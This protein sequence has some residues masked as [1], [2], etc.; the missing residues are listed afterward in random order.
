MNSP[1]VQMGDIQHP[2]KEM[3]CSTPSQKSFF[4]TTHALSH[5]LL[6]AQ[7]SDHG[8]S[9]PPRPNSGVKLGKTK[10]KGQVNALVRKNLMYQRRRP[11]SNICI[12]LLPILF[13][14][15]LTALQKLVIDK[16]LDSRDNKCGCLCLQCCNTVIKSSCRS[17]TSDDPVFCVD[18][19]EECKKYD[20][21]I[22][23]IEFSDPEQAV[24]CSVP[25]PASWPP[26][27]DI[28]KERNRAQP[29]SP[30]VAML[31]TGP[32][33]ITSKLIEFM[34]PS[35]D[36]SSL[37]SNF[38]RAFYFFNQST[39]GVLR[40]EGYSAAGVYF[41]SSSET[42]TSGLVEVAFVSENLSALTQSCEDFPLDAI[43]QAGAQLIDSVA[44]QGR[45]LIGERDSNDTDFVQCVDTPFLDLTEDEINRRLFCGFEEARCNAL[46]EEEQERATTGSRKI[47]QLGDENEVNDDDGP[48]QDKYSHAWDFKNS[49]EDR[50]DVDIWYE[51][52]G[53]VDGSDGPQDHQRVQL[54]MNLATTAWLK[55]V[56]GEDYS[57]QLLAL[58]DVPKKETK[59]TL[60]ISSL[61]A[62]ILF[63]WVM[64]LLLP[65]MLVQLVYE[66]ENRLRIMMKMHGLGDLA[67][68]LVNY[69]YYLTIY[70]VYMIVFLIIGSLVDLAIFTRNDYSVMI[71]FFFLFGNVQIAFAFVLSTFFRGSRT[72]TVFSFLWVFGTGL[73]GNLLVALLIQRDRWYVHL[74]E[75]IPAFGAYRG[76]FEM[77]QYGFRSAFSNDEGLKWS[78]FSEKNNHM[79]YIMA[80]FVVE[81]PL[82]F[83]LAWY[84][85]QVTVSGA[86]VK[87]SPLF[88]LEGFKKKKKGGPAR[89]PAVSAV[90]GSVPVDFESED[91]KQERQR[92]LGMTSNDLK[93]HSI[94]VN[95][96]R[97]VFPPIEGNPEKV[98]V[99][100]LTVAVRK[101]E[102]FGLLGPN[103][104][105]KTTSI[106]MLIGFL[107]PSSGYAFVDGFDIM[108][109]MQEIY[110]LMGVCPQHNL[111]W[112]T[113][114]GREHL[115]FYGRLKGLR[116]DELSNAADSALKSVHLFYGGVGNKKTQTYSGGMKRRLSVAISLIGNAKVVYLDEPS[117]GLDPASRRNLWDVVKNAKEDKAIIL[118]THSMKEAEVLCDRLGIFVGG[119]M[120]VI[121][122]PKEL[123][124]R[125]GGYLVFTLTTRPE[126]VAEACKLVNQTFPKATQT[127]SV[128]GTVKFELPSDH[129]A[130]SNV[131]DFMESAK[132]QIK[133]EDWG[134]ANVTLEEVFIKIAKE[135]GAKTDELT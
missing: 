3:Q 85:D 119:K 66:K 41:G 77:A 110:S 67:Y 132:K 51:D 31:Y 23:G 38:D 131:F 19:E 24:S 128:G 49:N 101:G 36:E 124:S 16:L 133:I 61:I 50:L 10:F 126:Y 37:L 93:E 45:S 20:D 118:T 92:V 62:V 14:G 86:G 1:D 70:S 99:Q 111:L 58:Q 76:L 27:M 35:V 130:T 6:T 7:P 83:L 5:G 129:V 43:N 79:G 34:L 81:W 90:G 52:T 87:R 84:L 26:I 116:G 96:L 112:N 114:T 15:L 69:L 108:S 30:G 63:T 54:P 91:V 104:A 122:N 28:P 102:V 48:R 106:N 98:A 89:G 107:S 117:T 21:T 72:S 18:D 123:T 40:G 75:L 46:E 33:S 53:T 82:F 109:D 42:T 11:C 113:L 56:V 12:V 59:L 127:Y 95:G 9:S 80:V 32:R 135:A 44:S 55:W 22:C 4:K 103:G 25:K 88:F 8:E 47:L 120:V 65:S 121:G 39:D 57:A 71:I 73:V 125:Y 68:W 60:E 100:D 97:K 115:Y 74:I 105:G 78:S 94:V 2:E 29:W 17:G 134:V 13:V 64:Q